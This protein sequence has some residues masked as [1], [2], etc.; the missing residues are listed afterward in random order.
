MDIPNERKIHTAPIPR[1]G[2]IAFFGAFLIVLIFSVY[3]W[4]QQLLIR[5][6]SFDIN[7][8]KGIII[9]CTCAMIIGIFDDI[10]ELNAILKLSLLIGLTYLV[11]QYGVIINFPIPYAGNLILTIFWIAG[12]TSAINALDHIDGLAAGISMIAA[13]AFFTVSLQTG[14]YFWG[15]VSLCMA[16]SLAGYL[17]FNWHPAKI[18]MGDSG[19]FFLGY[20]LA[21]ISVMGGWSENP[22]KAAIIPLTI[23]SL[24]IFDLIYVIFSRIHNGTTKNIKESILYCG[25]DHIGHRVHD[26]GFNTPNTVRLLYL[27]A[28]S[29]ALGALVLRKSNTLESI[30]LFSQ[31]VLFYIIIL[32]FMNL[33]H[34]KLTQNGEEEQKHK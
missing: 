24:P 11:S 29:I 13:F 8:L 5:E 18:F 17:I 4:K 15:L 21:S 16:G 14:Q 33:R 3:H 25:K 1:M 32:I 31:I 10:Y 7:N 12:F 28:G 19:S 27:I 34:S 30:F 9:G 2:G 22:I 26:L 20:T 6:N 23:L